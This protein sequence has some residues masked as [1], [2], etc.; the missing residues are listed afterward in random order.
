MLD[1]ITSAM[2]KMLSMPTVNEDFI[3]DDDISWDHHWLIEQKDAADFGSQKAEQVF[4]YAMPFI[5]KSHGLALSYTPRVLE[6]GCGIAKW[7]PLWR[8][9]GFIYDGLDGS[10]SA[11]RISR[12]RY[13]D[14]GSTFFLGLAQD[15]KFENVYDVIFTHAFLQ[16][17]SLDHKRQ[18][19]ARLHRALKPFGI[20]VLQEKCQNGNT[21]TTF[22]R[23]G[24]IDFIS[25]YG[26]RCLATTDDTKNGFVF[27]RVNK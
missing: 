10:P 4:D 23:Q 8:Q 7:S 17:T 12:E 18:I 24:W 19:F 22:T 14:F 26:F 15:M 2:W 13:P 5:F 9:L 16:H 3:G 27:V 20:L 1:T 11:V 25:F 21:E 6:I